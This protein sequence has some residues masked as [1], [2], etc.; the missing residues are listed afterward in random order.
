MQKCGSQ[1]LHISN[2]ACHPTGKNFIVRSIARP[3]TKYPFLI[4][5]FRPIFSFRFPLFISIVLYLT[6]C[7]NAQNS[8]QSFAVT[9]EGTTMGLIEA[10]VTDVEGTN[11]RIAGGIVIDISKA[12]IISVGGER[13]NIS[14]KP[15]M[16]IRA[17]IVGSDDKSSTLV[18]NLVRVHT[19]DRII[20]S[21]LLQEADLDNGSITLLNRRVLITSETVIPVGFKHRK[22]K[23]DLPV[24]VIV[25]PS[26]ADLVATIIFPK[27]V[28]AN[29]FP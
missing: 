21:G 3:M 17:G 29:I 2:P 18:A 1:Y 8:E 14:I 6:V 25:K 9:Q 28:L 20:L 24:S 19:E 7:V 22:L 16:C 15:G 13:L 10:V 27:I 4:R 5:S 11:L 23:A 26:G 12:I